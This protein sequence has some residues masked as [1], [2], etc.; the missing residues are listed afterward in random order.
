MRVIIA[1][2]IKDNH[3]PSDFNEFC[4]QE[5]AYFPIARKHSP[6]LGFVRMQG[7]SEPGKPRCDV[8]QLSCFVCG[9]KYTPILFK[10]EGYVTFHKLG[11]YFGAQHIY[12]LARC[13]HSRRFDGFSRILRVA[14]RPVPSVRVLIASRSRVLTYNLSQSAS[15]LVR[16]S[17]WIS[18]TLRQICDIL[19]TAVYGLN[20]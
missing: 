2:P 15:I 18:C 4:R 19:W 8:V 3:V 5:P 1:I 20:E 6:S 7:P 11:T 13:G 17:D 16:S 9:L 12:D 14:A 10:L